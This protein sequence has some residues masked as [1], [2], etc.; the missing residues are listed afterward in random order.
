MGSIPVIGHDTERLQQIDGSMP[1]LTEIPP[2][3]AFHPR[4]PEAF[5]RCV[6][7]RPDLMPVDNSQAAC[8][9]FDPRANPAADDG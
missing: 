9:L 8:W 7:E 6:A 1:R 5:G 3:C 2:G 4:C